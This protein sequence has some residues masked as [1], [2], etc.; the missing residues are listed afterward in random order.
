MSTIAIGDIH[1]NLRALEDLLSR[2]TP[3][4]N[5]GDTVVFLGDYIDR[6]AD[7]K[8]CIQTILDFRR[9]IN[10]RVVT[11]LGNHEEWMLRT[12]KDHTRHSW[13]LGMEG[14]QTVR[15]YS[16]TA[17]ERLREEAENLGPRLVLERPSLPYELFFDAMS[18]EH[19]SF[20]TSLHPFCR[21]PD[22]VCV[23][24]GLDPDA[25]RVEEQRSEDL[26]WGTDGFPDRYKGEEF[27]LYGHSNDFVLDERS[28][29]RP[30][31]VG[32]T[33][34]LDTISSG[35]LTAF[36]LPEGIAIQSERYG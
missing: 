6:G 9:T 30:R 22:A 5:A 3:E 16:T 35:V 24:G 19:I 7:A 20:L 1:G 31:I 18:A 21:T 33:C 29:P 8:G 32:R 4:I 11:L 17:A 25:G 14:F 26:L 13:L 12:Y 2:I 27:V 23:H 15:S 34:C 10:G 36:R 28:W